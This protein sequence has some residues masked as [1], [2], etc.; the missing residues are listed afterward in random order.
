MINWFNRQSLFLVWCGFLW[1]A[2]AMAQAPDQKPDAQETRLR[3]LLNAKLNFTSYVFNDGT[4]PQ[5]SFEQPA[6]I[7]ALLGPYAIRVTYYDRNYQRVETAQAPGLYG[8]MVEIVPKTGRAM[9]R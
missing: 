3:S 1:T 6:Q 2:P 8:A 7:E 9:Q 5:V 4:F